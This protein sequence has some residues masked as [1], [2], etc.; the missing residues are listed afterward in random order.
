MRW[1]G[2]VARMEGKKCL[3]KIV[4]KPEKYRS[5]GRPRCRWK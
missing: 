5:L 1:V 3:K 4:G 2:T